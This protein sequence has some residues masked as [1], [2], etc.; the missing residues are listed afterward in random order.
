MYSVHQTEPAGEKTVQEKGVEVVVASS[1]PRSG[2]TLLAQILSSANNSVLFFE[3]LSHY[4]KVPC[5]RNGSCV[6]GFIESL[7]ECAFD[8]TFDAWLKGKG[9]FVEYYHPAVAR[10]FQWPREGSS[11]CRR[12]LDLRALCRG[13]R[14]KVVKVIRSRLAWLAALL[15]APHIKVIHLT[16]DPRGA[17][18]SISRM[19]W[20]ASPSRRCAD[21]NADLDSYASL[22][23][24]HPGRIIQVSL[25]ELSL[26]PVAA[27]RT[28]FRFLSGSSLLEESTQAFLA[29]HTNA[30]HAWPN[31]A[32]MDTHRNSARE[33]EA[34]R[35]RVPA[36][37]LRAL[38][39]EPQCRAATARLGRGLVH[40]PRNIASSAV[41][42]QGTTT[43]VPKA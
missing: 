15:E 26:N 5:F 17:L 10:C 4:H 20:N 40:A 41:R 14:V 36:R 42:L 22:R 31:E 12:R 11:V 39:Q 30:S 43:R 29:E 24:R 35:T 6:P 7:F 1:L 37:Q 13:A 18:P 8:D 28:L 34:W 16:R 25:E 32:N 19:G 9:L 23:A 3:P 38:E 27:T 21:L 2:S 33:A